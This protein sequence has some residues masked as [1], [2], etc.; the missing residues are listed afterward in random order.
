MQQTISVSSHW[1]VRFSKAGNGGRERR[2][3]ALA[4][5][6]L[7]F[8]TLVMPLGQHLALTQA[9]PEPVLGGHHDR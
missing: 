9:S 7:G 6:V 4:P 5:S 8:A 1:S 2:C 3:W